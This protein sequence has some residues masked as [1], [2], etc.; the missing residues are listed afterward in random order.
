MGGDETRA[1]IL[2]A[3]GEVFAGHGYKESTVRDICQKAGVNV[4]SVNYYFGDKERLYIEAVKHARR[5]REQQEPLPGWAED[6][7]AS[8][9][10]TMFITTLT[11][12]MLGEQGDPWQTRLIM[13]EIME[14]TKAC[15]EMVQEAFQPYFQILLGILAEMMPDDTPPHELH[16]LGFGVIGQCFYYRSNDKI[17]AMLV[18]AEELKRHYTPERLA[19]QISDMVLAAIGQRPALGCKSSGKKFVNHE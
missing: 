5:L 10:L 2:Q 8:A 7:P 18:S 1:R 4:A 13:R 11:R 17:V 6:T 12:R 19:L 9:K 15:E 16:Q 3:A 14:P